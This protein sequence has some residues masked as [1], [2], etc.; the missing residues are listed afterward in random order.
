MLVVDNLELWVVVV[1]L[2]HSHSFIDSNVMSVRVRPGGLASFG[3]RLVAF[4][5]MQY[6]LARG[7][8]RYC[9]RR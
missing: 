4:A 7:V 6:R 8:R 1:R 2:E 3:L 5:M 9:W